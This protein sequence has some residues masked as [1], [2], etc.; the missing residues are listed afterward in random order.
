MPYSN[1]KIIVPYIFAP[2]YKVDLLIKTIADIR[3]INYSIAEHR[4]QALQRINTLQSTNPFA[5]GRF[6]HTGLYICE[7]YGDWS[8]KFAQL[9]STLSY[10]EPS[11]AFRPM[12]TDKNLGSEQRGLVQ[13]F[14]DSAVSFANILI[15]MITQINKLDGVFNRESFELTFDV[16]WIAATKRQ[17][18]PLNRQKR[19]PL[20]GFD[21]KDDEDIE[22]AEQQLEN[23]EQRGEEPVINPNKQEVDQNA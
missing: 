10:K 2:W 9:R 23:Q 17:Q 16:E 13:R 21:F 19:D 5:N 4:N 3:K 8:R 12:T 15:D 14:N 18:N 7:T 20:L 11:D 1:E 22:E 6:N